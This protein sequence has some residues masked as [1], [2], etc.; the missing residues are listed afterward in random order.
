MKFLK[1]AM[2]SKNNKR[3]EKNHIFPELKCE[4]LS[5]RTVSVDGS[6]VLQFVLILKVD[7]SHF[8]PPSKNDTFLLDVLKSLPEVE[9]N[10]LRKPQE[11]LEFKMSNSTKLRYQ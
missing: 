3:S 6:Q 4:F 9:E 10:T 5:Y 1:T 8:A 11:T 7:I 2:A